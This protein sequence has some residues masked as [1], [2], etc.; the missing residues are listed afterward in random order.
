MSNGYT[1]FLVIS[2]NTLP[3]VIISSVR[4]I[5]ILPVQNW[6]SI[7]GIINLDRI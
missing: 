5:L 4:L 3:I 2:A 7:V 6:Q 1:E